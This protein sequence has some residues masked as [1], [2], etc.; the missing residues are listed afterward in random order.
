M[1]TDPVCHMQVDE[2]GAQWT[3]VH[4]GRRYCFCEPTCKEKF[5]ADPER[6]IAGKKREENASTPAPDR[7]ASSW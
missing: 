1:A 7:P 4:D 5:D 2:Q 6:F 3:S